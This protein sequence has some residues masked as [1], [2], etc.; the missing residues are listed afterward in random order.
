MNKIFAGMSSENVT[1]HLNCLNTAFYVGQLDF[2]DSARCLVQNYLL[3]AFS[4]IIITTIAAKCMSA[5]DIHP[6]KGP[7]LTSRS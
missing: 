2:R 1:S 3:L 6:Y 4:V 7:M 5:F